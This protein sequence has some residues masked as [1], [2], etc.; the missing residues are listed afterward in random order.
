LISLIPKAVSGSRGPQD[1]R[2]ELVEGGEQA[3]GD[4]LIIEDR[5]FAT[6]WAIEALKIFGHYLFRG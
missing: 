3:N 4:S 6:V 5:V 2:V 1:R